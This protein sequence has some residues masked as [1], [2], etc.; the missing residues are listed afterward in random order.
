MRRA[1]VRVVRGRQLRYVSIR[2]LV[3]KQPRQVA[4]RGMERSEHKANGGAGLALTK[5]PNDAILFTCFTIGAGEM[6]LA[7]API[8]LHVVE[9]VAGAVS[10]AYLCDIDFVGNTTVGPSIALVAHTLAEHTQTITRAIR[11]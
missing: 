4:E 5:S 10:S 1:L 2:Q 3:P 8:S 9:A 11:Q 6:L 7:F